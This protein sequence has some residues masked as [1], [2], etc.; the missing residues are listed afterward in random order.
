MRLD[1][2]DLPEPGE[3]W[4]LAGPDDWEAAAERY[5]PTSYDTP[6]RRCLE[7]A[8][9]CG[10]RSLVIETRYIDRDYRS[11][12]SD[13]FSK[14]FGHVPD[15]AHRLHF[16]SDEL[17]PTQVT[18]LPE[19][20]DYI[21]YIVIRPSTLGAVGRTMLRPPPDVADAV[22]TAVEDRVNLYGQELAV[23]G[24]PFV[25]QDAQL[26]RCAHAAA[27]MTHYSAHLRGEVA[28]RMMADFST[29]ADPSLG[30]GRPI[31]S[32]GLTVQQL[33]E[34]LRKFGLPPIFYRVGALPSIRLPWAPPAPTPPAGDPNLDAGR[35]DTRIVPVACRH[36]NSGRPVMVGTRNHAF[37]L[38]GFRREV[39]ADGSSWIHF[40]RHDDQRGPYLKV[41]DVLNDADASVPYDY[42]PWVTLLA[43]LPEKL[44]LSPESAEL[45]GGTTLHALSAQLPE[46]LQLPHEPLHAMLEQGLAALRTYA[47][48]ANDFKRGLAT[49][50][51]D[52]NLQRE[53]R[54]A[55]L[56]RY[57]WVVEAVSR[58]KRSNG[59]PC[60]LG[61]AIFDAT[62]SDFQPTVLAL[63]VPGVA[64]IYRTSG[65][66]RYPV[67]CA[68]DSYS[69]GGFGPP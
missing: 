5:L 67:Y 65:A 10:A 40:I 60:V 18:D 53:Y 45:V 28:R 54:T 6:L 27:W 41:G 66:P 8:R 56:S 25:Q 19:N 68:T 31:P 38:C 63:H 44:W 36:L 9:E 7:V 43:A 55:R 29:E 21:G 34:L 42:G 52:A 47:I 49:R 15:A 3:F 59:D 37:V 33:S 1:G 16:F 22:R 23:T 2:W 39:H 24:V 11:E 46:A 51:V 48:S 61:E 58:E 17:E 26:G 4:S 12:Y 50:G 20:V 69:S 30:I 35:W 13:F 57:V 64:A 14:A 32:Q 62:S